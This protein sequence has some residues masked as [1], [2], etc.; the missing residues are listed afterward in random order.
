VTVDVV[1][2]PLDEAEQQVLDRLLSEDF[3]GVD[4]LRVQRASVLAQRTCRCGCASIDLVVDSSAPLASV[5]DTVAVSAH[6]EL[7]EPI[8]PVMIVLFVHDG[9]LSLMEIASYGH[10]VPDRWPACEDL[11]IERC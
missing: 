8:G 4:R 2:R 7:P 1:P 11:D 3:P 5:G 6:A 10:H 9:R